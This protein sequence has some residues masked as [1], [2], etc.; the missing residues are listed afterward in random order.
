VHQPFRLRKDY[1]FFDIGQDHMYEDERTNRA[2]MNK[3]SEKCYLPA[4]Q[5][6]LDLIEEFKGEFKIAYSITGL[7]VEQ[8][9]KYNPEVI[10]SFKRLNDTGCV[11]FLGET[12]Y[13]SL[14]FLYSR[15]E[16]KKQVVKHQQLMSSLFGVKPLTFRN[17]ELIY[18]NDLANVIEEMGYDVILSEGPEQVLG[19]RSP[20]FVYQPASCYKLKLL[21]KNYRLSD[22]IA[23]RFSNQAWDGYP[24]RPE[25]FAR[26]LHNV[27]GNGETINLFM[28]YETIGEHQWADTGIFDFFKNLPKQVLNRTDFNFQTPREVCQTYDPMAQLNAC[29]YISWADTER[30]V[31]AWVGNKMQNSAIESLSSMEKDIVRQGNEDYLNVWRKLQSSDHLYYMSTKWFSDG[32]VHQY[33]N[34]YDSPHE[35]YITFMNVLNDLNVQVKKQNKSK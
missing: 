1:S 17:T 15:S 23:F 5:L 3:V 6:M 24:L 20:N 29:D 13:H 2:I 4:N 22:D 10:D 27:S 19:W 35:A 7:A 33:F 34:P 16:F 31:S 32:A 12:Y 8:F 26:W 9:Q 30:D 18:S 11:E 25:T 21:L 14:A 28:D